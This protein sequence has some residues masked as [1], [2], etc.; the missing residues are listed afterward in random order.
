MLP[1]SLK[2]H[3]T[4]ASVEA[5]D[6]D[7]LVTG[8]FDRGELTLEI[9][10]DKIVRLCRFLKDE[11]KFVRLSTIAGVDR[12]PGEPRFE[13]VYHLHSLERNQRLRV[14]CRLPGVD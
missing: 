13:V 5:F 9:A 12:H 7:A 3:A 1:E 4:A 8:K 11:L 14:K 2:E 6:A 10:P